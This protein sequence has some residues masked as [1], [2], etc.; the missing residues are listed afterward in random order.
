MLLKDKII[1][2]LCLLFIFTLIL[3]CE[4][5]SKQNNVNG[6]NINTGDNDLNLHI[7]YILNNITGYY[8]VTAKSSNDEFGIYSHYIAYISIENN[9]LSIKKFNIFDGKNNYQ[10]KY[11][12]GLKTYDPYLQGFSRGRYKFVTTFNSDN[13]ISEIYMLI[14]DHFSNMPDVIITDFVFISSEINEELK[15]YTYDYQAR[16]TGK[17]KFD[18]YI[19]HRI[20]YDDFINIEYDNE[21]II[22]IDDGWLVLNKYYNGIYRTKLIEKEKGAILYW[23]SPAHGQETRVYLFDNY[24]R[25]DYFY[26][27]TNFYA[28]INDNDSY[29]E[30][31]SFSGYQLFYVRE[32]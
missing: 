6:S 15:K 23:P 8:N 20:E 16:F 13:Q 9:F 31:K 4:K 12:F 17:Y 21:V 1:K 32:E 25:F 7:E 28:Y 27:L 14:Y 2:F 19:L 22:G 18:H 3:S 30:E 10:E 26:N 11:S 5:S 24:I 29:D